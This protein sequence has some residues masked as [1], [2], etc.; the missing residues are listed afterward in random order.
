M[1]SRTNQHNHQDMQMSLY[2]RIDRFNGHTWVTSRA[3]VSNEAGQTRHSL[4]GEVP[5]CMKHICGVDPVVIWV[6]KRKQAYSVCV[7]VSTR[8]HC[9]AT[10]VSCNQIKAAYSHT[11]LYM[12]DTGKKNSSGPLVAEFIFTAA[13]ISFR[14]TEAKLKTQG[15]RLIQAY[16]VCLCNHSQGHGSSSW[17]LLQGSWRS[18]TS[19]CLQRACRRP[20]TQKSSSLQPSPGLN[21]QH[22]TC[23]KCTII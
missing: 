2:V 11:V 17:I 15:E 14:W 8:V 13:N 18:Q 20:E 21:N 3:V 16:M 12:T 19:Q 5:D 23:K 22:S 7:T 4:R 10:N 1:D 6:R 9:W